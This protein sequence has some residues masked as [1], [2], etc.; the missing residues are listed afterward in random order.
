MKRN[1][2]VALDIIKAQIASDAG[3]G[4]FSEY[5]EKYPSICKKGY[6][7]KDFYILSACKKIL[8][9]KESGFYF[10][11]THCLDQ[12]GNKS[13]LIYFNFRI[14]GK[15]KQI[16][17]HSFDKELWKPF[18]KNNCVTRWDHDSSRLAAEELYKSIM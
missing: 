14:N 15:R 3:K 11:V 13:F 16:S 5:A 7:V 12:N 6:A 18:C 2:A 9:S 8:K 10:Y 4:Y 17:F 1:S